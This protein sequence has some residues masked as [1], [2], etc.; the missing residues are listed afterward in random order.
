MKNKMIGIAAV[1]LIA[2][3]F[4]GV[5]YALWSKT[6]YIYGTVDTGDVDAKFGDT[7]CEASMD[8]EGQIPVPEEKVTFT[9]ECYPDEED[10]QILHVVI[11]DLYPSIWIHCYFKIWNTGTVPWIVQSAG[12]VPNGVFPGDL[13]FTPVDLV[14]TQVE[15]G[16]FTVADL[17]IH[18]T[19]DA[20][21]NS[22]YYFAVEILVVQWNEYVQPQP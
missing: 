3:M 17:E 7:W 14:G 4:A 15:P 1:L 12:L 8:Q 10:P 19:N 13:T 22:V 6:L 16:F 20:L 9:F 11:T 2:L 5:S 18:L 21:E